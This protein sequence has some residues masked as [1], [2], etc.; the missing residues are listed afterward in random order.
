[1]Q[2]IYG[3]VRQSSV[4]DTPTPPSSLVSDIV[5]TVTSQTEVLS[6]W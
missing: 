3:W 6:S 1:M 4:S 5:T 2:I